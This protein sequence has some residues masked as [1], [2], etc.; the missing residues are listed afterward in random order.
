MP[1]KTV[2]ERQIQIYGQFQNEIRKCTKEENDR[3]APEGEPGWYRHQ[4]RVRAY[5]KRYAERE[6]ALKEFYK[7]EPIFG[8]LAGMS[9]EEVQ[10]ITEIR[11]Q[12]KRDLDA[13]KADLDKRLPGI[14]L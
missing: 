5:E 10:R 11:Q 6:K 3:Y 2:I 7:D 12:W 4:E 8:S 9:T 14:Q 13:F 1:T